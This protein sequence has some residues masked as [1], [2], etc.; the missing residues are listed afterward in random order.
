[1]AGTVLPRRDLRAVELY[2]VHTHR[3]REREMLHM[4]YGTAQ[5]SG[6]SVWPQ[7]DISQW[8]L[9]EEV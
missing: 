9:P 8:D 6:S 2:H 4:F 3:E 1:M 5:H 7:S